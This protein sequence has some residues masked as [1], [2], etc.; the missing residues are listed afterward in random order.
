MVVDGGTRRAH[1][2]VMLG[3]SLDA[4]CIRENGVYVDGTFGRGGHSM[5]ILERLGPQ[6]RLIAIDR[7]PA[8]IEAGGAITD[9]RFCLVHARFSELLVVLQR[10]SVLSVDGVLLDLGVSSPQLDDAQRGFSFKR[11]G[12]LDMRMDTTQ[13][14]SA[15][16]WLAQA[17]E[18]EIFEVLR[19]Y[20]EERAAFQ[21]AK[22]I[23]TR[24][25]DANSAP[26]ETTGQLAALVAS[27]VGRGSGSKGGR[28]ALGK[29]PATRSFQAIRIFINQEL[30]E[31]TRT[32]ALALTALAPQGRLAVISFHSLEDRIVKQF[33]AQASGKSEAAIAQKSR[34]PHSTFRAQVGHALQKNSVSASIKL[35]PKLLASELES[36]TNPRSRSA[37]LRTAEKLGPILNV[38]GVPT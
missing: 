3:E 9:A 1:Q 21:I 27:V 32:L 10:L 18:Q 16:Q 17:S 19:D 29:D 38:Q 25:G 33:F 5:A 14:I 4:L 20:G 7:D 31:L 28:A 8:A 12:P 26:L 2:S 22:K 6:G 13:G 34:G 15:K 35:L 36:S 37:V 24:R 30:E 11:D 23:V